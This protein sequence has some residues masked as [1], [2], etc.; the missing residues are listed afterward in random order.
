MVYSKHFPSPHTL[1]PSLTSFSSVTVNVDVD[2][3][4][5]GGHVEGEEPRG[6]DTAAAATKN[7]TLTLVTIK[8]LGVEGE[9]VESEDVEEG[10]DRVRMIMASNFYHFLYLHTLTPSHTHTLPYSPWR[11]PSQ[12][13]SVW[14]LAFVAWYYWTG[15]TSHGL[16]VV[17]LSLLVPRGNDV[18]DHQQRRRRRW[19]W[20]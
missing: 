12:H 7:L 1:L 6:S 8:R 3:S 10:R 2:S 4:L 11:Q 5:S 18:R 9:G 20:E 16:S 17:P 15:R 13:Q 19:K 14:R